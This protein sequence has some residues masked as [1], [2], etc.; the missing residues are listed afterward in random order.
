MSDIEFN[1]KMQEHKEKICLLKFFFIYFFLA[2]L[3]MA[4]FQLAW[5]YMTS[6]LNAIE[7]SVI[8]LEIV[9]NVV[10][11]WCIHELYQA[12]KYA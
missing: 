5:F 9:I 3:L 2:S 4:L 6:S 12:F 10:K 7:L 8:I 11:L 1:E